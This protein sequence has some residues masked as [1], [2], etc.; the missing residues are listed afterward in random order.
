MT[1]SVTVARHKKNPSPTPFVDNSHERVEH[2][3]CRR[4]I[5]FIKCSTG[6]PGKTCLHLTFAMSNET[7]GNMSL[8]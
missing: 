3:I 6:H 5:F 7:Y 2:L 1:V 4:I 8:L